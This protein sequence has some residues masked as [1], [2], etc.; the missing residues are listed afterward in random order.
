MSTRRRK[1]KAWKRA[2]DWHDVFFHCQVLPSV[3]GKTDSSL[4]GLFNGRLPRQILSKI[5]TFLQFSD[6]TDSV[7]SDADRALP[8]AFEH[9]HD[10]RGIFSE[11]DF[12]GMLSDS[13][14]KRYSDSDDCR[15]DGGDF[16]DATSSDGV[17]S[18]ALDRMVI[19]RRRPRRESQRAE[20]DDTW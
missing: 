4:V 16:G 5:E 9:E 12:P 14:D 7:A 1:K 20:R 10:V 15:C 3:A 17:H 18:S 2:P 8:G 11:S 6:I 19:L 13:E